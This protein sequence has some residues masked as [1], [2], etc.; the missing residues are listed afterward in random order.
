LLLRVRWGLPA[1]MAISLSNGPR[2][3]QGVGR[4]NATGALLVVDA[5]GSLMRRHKPG[6][7]L[8]DSWLSR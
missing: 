2:Q 1:S 4:K 6:Q 8:E 5:I 7:S 3:P